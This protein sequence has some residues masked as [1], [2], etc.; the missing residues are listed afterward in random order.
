MGF[1]GDMESSGVRY[2]QH[3]S[4]P[5]G[6]KR[7]GK[8]PRVGLVEE[9]QALDPMKAVAM[10]PPRPGPI[11][12]TLVR[13]HPKTGQPL[14]G[15]NVPNLAPPK[16]R[17]RGGGVY[18]P[19]MYTPLKY[20]PDSALMVAST[21][22]KP[23]P[24]KMSMGQWYRGKETVPPNYFEATEEQMGK[25]QP[26]GAA[27]DAFMNQV[28]MDQVI[29]PILRDGSRPAQGI[30]RVMQPVTQPSTIANR[31]WSTAI[32][33][34]PWSPQAG[35]A[36]MGSSKP[37]TPQR[38]M[39]QTALRSGMVILGIGLLGLFGAAFLRRSGK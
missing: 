11:S 14:P 36:G 28:F 3:R 32:P 22:L 4:E 29:K 35:L 9:S 24:R 18:S 12:K 5:I 21:R 8:L 31:R 25:L 37:P 30:H 34:R 1:F 19:R 6:S 27:S 17:P 13:V 39:P 38:L 16:N 2:A 20:T 10:K 26:R 15:W 23:K 33:T 7:R